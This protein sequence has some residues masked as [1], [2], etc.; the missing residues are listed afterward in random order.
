MSTR[1]K[2]AERIWVSDAKKVRRLRSL[3]FELAHFRNLVLIFIHEYHRKT[4][5]W[6]TSSAILYSLMSKPNSRSL[7]NK[8]KVE[9]INE[10]K[11]NLDDNLKEW[12]EKIK[13]QKAK[14]DNNYAVQ[15]VLRQVEKDF[16]SY[17]SSLEENEKNPEKF[18]GKPNPPKPKKLKNLAHFTVELN[19]NAIEQNGRRLTLKLRING[20]RRFVVKLSNDFKVTSARICYCLGGIYIDVIR[21]VEVPSVKPLGDHVAGIDLNLDNLLTITSTNPSLD[22]L[23]ITG[24][25]LKAFNQW[26]N[27][28]KSELQSEADRI[29]NQIDVLKEKGEDVTELEERE[30]ELRWRIR[31]LCIHRKKWMDNHFHRLTKYLALYFY[32]TGH[33]LVIVGKGAMEAKQNCELGRTTEKFV[34]I[35]YRSLIDKLKYKLSLLGIRLIEVDEAYTSQASCINDDI[36]KIHE[37]MKKGE[38]DFKPTGKREKR[39]LYKD[40]IT[41]DGKKRVIVYHADCN[42]SFNIM[43]LGAK[44]PRPTELFD[45]KTLMKKL[46][47]PVKIRMFKFVELMQR[48]IPRSLRKWRVGDSPALTAGSNPVAFVQTFHSTLFDNKRLLPYATG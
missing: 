39:G 31:R 47:N 2:L 22:T 3:V 30:K 25:E 24:G 43:R 16:R 26:F 48:V 9:K 8:E 6:L 46:C 33:D 29:R 37:K 20:K 17:F 1:I 13:E 32:T 45:L 35:P 11:N 38:H 4:G 10:V 21:E 44:L 12:L 27:K 23:I 19:S 36:I 41:V 18:N 34:Q 7:N 42:G 28:L 5:K 40:T 14:I 15:N